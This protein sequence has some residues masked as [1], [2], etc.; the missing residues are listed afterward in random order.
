MAVEWMLCALAQLRWT[1]RA[2]IFMS[3]TGLAASVM[4]WA[5]VINSHSILLVGA[6]GL[7]TRPLG[8]LVS[9]MGRTFPNVFLALLFLLFLDLDE[10]P[11]PLELES[12][13]L[14]GKGH[15]GRLRRGHPH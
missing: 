9:P 12:M 4:S 15:H 6:E 8:W 13:E 11:L 3:N 7:F 2:C 10:L 1:E 14:S 5:A